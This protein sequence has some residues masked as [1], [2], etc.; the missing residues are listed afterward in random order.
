MFLFDP[1][2]LAESVCAR[3]GC[4]VGARALDDGLVWGVEGIG[5]RDRAARPIPQSTTFG[6]WAV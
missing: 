6:G 2:T 3:L 5:S 4:R 1:S